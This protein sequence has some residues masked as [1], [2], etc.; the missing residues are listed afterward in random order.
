[1]AVREAHLCA[2]RMIDDA[3]GQ[4]V[5][6]TR[7]Q[8]V[9]YLTQ[10]AGFPVGFEFEYRHYGPFSEELA[11]A[12]EIASGLGLVQEEERRADWGGRY[13]IYRSQGRTGATDNMRMKFVSAA[14]KID[15]VELELA[16]TAAFL[17]AVDGVGR[18]RPGDP[19]AETVK[20]KP[21]KAIDGRLD[22][23]KAAY[24]RLRTLTTPVAL[25]QIE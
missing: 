3:G 24:N 20:L 9:A 2:A 23:A 4:L 17:Y 18:L 25:P 14:A 12:M 5:G 8:K 22:R 6:R 19:W 16:A 21:E 7:L 1:M 11:T 15:A 13:S 10:L